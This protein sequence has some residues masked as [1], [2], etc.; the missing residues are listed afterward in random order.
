M[1][2]QHN[3]IQKTFKLFLCCTTLKQH[4]EI[5]KKWCYWEVQLWQ[6]NDIL[7]GMKEFLHLLN[8]LKLLLIHSL[9]WLFKFHPRKISL[10]QENQFPKISTNIASRKLQRM[11]HRLTANFILLY[12]K[13][14]ITLNIL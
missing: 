10:K 11:L 6:F 1:I 8:W 3:L 14:M 2:C 9:S 12:F 5:G 13:L 7:K 4:E